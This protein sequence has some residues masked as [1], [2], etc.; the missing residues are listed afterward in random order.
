MITAEGWIFIPMSFKPSLRWVSDLMRFLLCSLLL[1]GAL[2]SAAS[3]GTL[4]LLVHPPREDMV[5]EE[6]YALEL[7]QGERR[8]FVGGLPASVIL[9]SRQADEFDLVAQNVFSTSG[10]G[11]QRMW[12]Q[13]VFSGRVNAP[14]YL[15][16]NDEIL[17]YIREHPGT[18][19]IVV[20]EQAPAGVTGF[21]LEGP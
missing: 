12:F 7:M 10:A 19:G 6:Q 8:S 4:F 18:V 16:S 9:P 1:L 11:M 14:K 3:E 20:S 2:R 15:N 21:R 17:N 5:V 13:M